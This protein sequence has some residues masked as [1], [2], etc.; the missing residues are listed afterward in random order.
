MIKFPLFRRINIYD[1]GLFP[2]ASG[3]RQLIFDFSPNVSLIA[4]VNGLGKTTLLTMLLRSLTGPYDLKES[5]FPA[6]LEAILPKAP[7]KLNRAALGFFAQRVADNAEKSRMTVDVSFGEDV[8][9]VT[10]S[11]RNMSL[12]ALEIDG[13]PL[14]LESNEEKMK[15]KADLEKIQ[16]NK[17]QMILRDLMGVTTFVDVLIVLHYVVFSMER[18][19]GALWDGH[20]QRQLLRAILLEND[21]VEQLPVL[22][23]DASQIDGEFRRARAEAN[24][25]QKELQSARVDA[26]SS[27]AKRAALRAIQYALAGEKER[28]EELMQQ[29]V[30]LGERRK[31]LRQNLER[32][33]HSRAGAQA[34]VEKQKFDMLF[35][36][37]PTADDAVTLTLARILADEECLV[38][39]ADAKKR[40]LEIEQQLLHKRCPVCN[41]TFQTL[42]HVV[43]QNNL[44]ANRL[45]RFV[46]EAEKAETEERTL[47]L[48]LSTIDNERNIAIAKME[49]LKNSIRDK[50]DKVHIYGAQTLEPKEVHELEKTVDFLN[51]KKDQ[52]AADS[53]IARKRLSD[54]YDSARASFAAIT[55][56]ISDAFSDAIKKMIAEDAR[57]VRGQPTAKMM[58]DGEPF[59]V[60]GFHVEMTAADRSGKAERKHPDDVS[61]SQR[62]LVDLAFRMALL[63]VAGRGS[64]CSLVMET[65]EASLDAIAMRRVGL[66]LAEFSNR[67]KNR[68]IVTNNLTNTDMISSLFGGPS[69]SVNL[70][71]DRCKQ[72]LNLL[73]EAAPNEAVKENREAYRNILDIALSGN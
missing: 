35:E 56:G 17:F 34:V 39:G 51:N 11:L 22:E 31:E 45:K 44:E 16:E 33:K 60:F 62:E 48:E 43:P 41:S 26:Q 36:L 28:L 59:K 21:L 73:E 67:G 12:I 7:V 24:K 68:L 10:R 63:D 29:V 5:G 52:L 55:G 38:C 9:R 49:E 70:M 13:V 8:L 57:L 3:D 19:R 64:G 71:D 6:T 47:L 72:I 18:R 69:Q 23:R 4:G 2:G 30:E 14:E 25:Y 1:Y 27:P 37:F 46:K 53:A 54:A 58:Q 50:S 32:A 65:P 15:P 40:R 20:A 61:E 66:A 42:E